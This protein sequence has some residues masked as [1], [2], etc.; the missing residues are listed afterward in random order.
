MKIFISWSKPNSN[1][2]ALALKRFISRIFDDD[3]DIQFFISS[4]DIYAGEKWFEVISNELTNS[5]LAIICLTQE[6]RFSKWLDFESGAIAFN[7]ETA[8]V[9]PFLFNIDSLEE[10]NPLKNF[11]F[12]KNNRQDLLRLIKTIRQKSS[13]TLTANQIEILFNNF[14][15]TLSGEFD[16]IKKGTSAAIDSDFFDQNIYPRLV[17]GTIDNKV[18]IGT[19]MASIDSN[20]YL[21]NRKEILA[22]IDDIRKHCKLDDIY[23]PIITNADSNNFDGQEKAMEMDFSILKQSEY[24]VFIYPYKTASSVLVEIG[25]AIALIKKTIIFVRNRKDLPF[26]LE[27]ADKRNSNIKIYEYENF[28]HLKK[29]IKDEGE[30]MFKFR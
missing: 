26:M 18:F 5:Q 7:K 1:S 2:V 15:N 30:F 25:Y 29:Q 20:Q 16:L 4:E 8:I 21:E 9:C 23:S 22:L 19:P 12:T 24:Y 3:I 13:S 14:Y 28:T 6:N 17:K 11:Q 10:G 27:K